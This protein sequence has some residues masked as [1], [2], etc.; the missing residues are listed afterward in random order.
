[1]L[2]LRIVAPPEI[3]SRT[4]EV[5]CASESVC[6][7]VH[8]EGVATDP[9]GDLVLA[10]VARE[11]ASVVIDDLKDLDVEAKGSIS[12]QEIDAELSRHN[13]RAE[14]RAGGT[15][16]DAVVWEEVQTRT[17]EATELSVSYL[18]FMV[19]AA[20][21]ALVAIHLDNPVLLV[22]A[23]VV[24]PEF[25]PLAGF[26]VAAVTRRRD[27]ALRS[28]VALAVGFP[29]A[30][31]AVFATT[32]A[33]RAVGL[34]PGDLALAEG[35]IGDFIS[36]PDFL[37]FFVAACA[38]VAGVLSLSTAKSSALIG[39]L[40]SVTTIPAASGV[41]LAAAYGDGDAWRGSLLQLGINFATILAFGT[42]ALGIQR[43][44]YHRRLRRH[45]REVPLPTKN[46]A[47]PH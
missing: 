41:G 8:L 16:T 22:G 7:I 15:P 19:V 2:H 40:I 5:L 6:N 25:G 9:D 32:L 35:E 31:T 30:I 18:V 23:M 27:V 46:D 33:F 1:M 29:V 13:E 42:I 44:L 38:G 36:S 10:D 24:G 43:A 12:V 20:L 26:C 14:R 34:M 4:L 3:A 37:S 47:A 39:V 45:E 21:I 28:F 11:D 17:S